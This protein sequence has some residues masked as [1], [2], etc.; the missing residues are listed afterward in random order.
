VV[1][2]TSITHGKPVKNS[3]SSLP[4]NQSIPHTPSLRDIISTPK[5]KNGCSSQAEKAPKEGK[6]LRGLYSFSEKFRDATVIFSA[7]PSAATSGFAPP[8][9]NGKK[10]PLP[11]LVMMEPENPTDSIAT[12]ER[13]TGNSSSPRGGRRIHQ[14]WRSIH[15]QTQRALSGLNAASQAPPGHPVRIFSGQS[16]RKIS[17]LRLRHSP[18]DLRKQSIGPAV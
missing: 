17:P 16:F 14:V 3:V 8:K 2:A 4:L 1:T 9:E 10:S 7:R 6:R 11:N 5:R 15:P 12:W 13:Q 18:R